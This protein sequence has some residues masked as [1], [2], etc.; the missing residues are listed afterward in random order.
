MYRGYPLQRKLPGVPAPVSEN[1]IYYKDSCDDDGQ[2]H[3]RLPFDRLSQYSNISEGRG[4]YSVGLAFAGASQQ[5]SRKDCFI[6]AFLCQ[7][8]ELTLMD[9]SYSIMAH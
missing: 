5:P 6:S 7:K 8:E 4:K 3:M 9:K 1:H 2:F